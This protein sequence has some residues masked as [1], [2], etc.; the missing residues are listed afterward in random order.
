MI[1]SKETTSPVKGKEGQRSASNLQDIPVTFQFGT[2]EGDF[3]R[4]GEVLD[5]PERHMSQ[6][7]GP[8]GVL[9]G[10]WWAM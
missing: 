1:A 7:K 3:E 9:G 10:L 6:S 8:L 4:V 5:A 2:I